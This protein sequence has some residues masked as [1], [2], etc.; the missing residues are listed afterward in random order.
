MKINP[1]TKPPTNPLIIGENGLPSGAILLTYL[2]NLNLLM[3]S[4]PITMNTP[5]KING[6]TIWK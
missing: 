6:N 1:I 5:K 4:M 2:N 3:T